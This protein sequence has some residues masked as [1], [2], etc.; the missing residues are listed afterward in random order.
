MVE[1]RRAFHEEL[2]ELNADVLRLAALATEAI[3]AGSAALLDFDL[4]GADKVIADDKVIDELTHAMEEQVYLLLAR[5]QPMASDLRT[6][7]SILRVIHELERVG[8]LMKNV[9]KATRSPARRAPGLQQKRFKND[10]R[11][12]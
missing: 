8:D 5:Q 7:V 2:E 9:A 12:G 10:L 4:A 3:Q 11:A 6:L 1:T